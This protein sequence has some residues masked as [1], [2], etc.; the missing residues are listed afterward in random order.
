M[1]DFITFVKLDLC[2]GLFVLYNTDCFFQMCTLTAHTELSSYILSLCGH[3]FFLCRCSPPLVR[4]RVLVKSETPLSGAPDENP[5]K[6]LQSGLRSRERPGSATAHKA[7]KPD[8][9]ASHRASD[10]E[11][12]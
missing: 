9:A 12:E 5:L 4:L 3:Y 2:K 11:E 10:A 6:A 8:V 1:V 7:I